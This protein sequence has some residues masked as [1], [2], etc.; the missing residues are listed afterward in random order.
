MTSAPR[1]Q[2]VTANRT[3]KRNFGLQWT[4]SLFEVQSWA[5]LKGSP[6]ARIAQ[7][8]LYVLGSTAMQSHMLRLTGESGL[9]RGVN[10]GLSPEIVANSPTAQPNV[11]AGLRMDTAF[12][13]ENQAKLRQRFEGW[14]AGR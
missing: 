14:Q 4:A 8:L 11:A 1:A 12:W 5:I 10:E 7:Q 13:N 6:D 9:A 2:V 3:E